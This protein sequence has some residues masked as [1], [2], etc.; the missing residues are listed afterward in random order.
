MEVLVAVSCKRSCELI[1]MASSGE[2][3]I[4]WFLLLSLSPLV[5]STNDGFSTWMSYKKGDLFKYSF[6]GTF[7]KV[8]LRIV[9]CYYCRKASCNYCKHSMPFLI[10]VCQTICQTEVHSMPLYLHMSV[11]VFVLEGVQSFDCSTSQFIAIAIHCHSI[12][13]KIFAVAIFGQVITHSVFKIP[14]IRPFLL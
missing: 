14:D 5:S 7:R 1:L 3:S 8:G 2:R 6:D 11:F 10:T 4:C 13:D 12:D 9:P